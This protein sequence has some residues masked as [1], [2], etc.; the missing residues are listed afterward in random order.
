MQAGQA[1]YI[2][3]AA[4][5]GQ[6]GEGTVVGPPL[7][8]SE[9]VNGPEENLIRIQLRGL[10]GPIT[11]KGQEYNFPTGMIPMA[12]QTDEQIAAVLT[13]VR[14]SFGNNAPAV[15][16]TSVAALRSEAGQPMLKQADLIPPEAV[17]PIPAD[18]GAETT[19]PIGI[20]EAVAA[21]LSTKYDDL[22][23][24]LGVP[25]WVI[26]LIVA[27]LAVSLFPLFARNH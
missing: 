3:C 2:M 17:G 25:G 16:P 11:V 7:A 15:S 18:H 22:S 4:C 12:Y 21:P 23:P 26:G 9:W 24:G 20:P 8:G 13:F 1:Q 6:S 5:H 19:A 14:N 10:E 27:F